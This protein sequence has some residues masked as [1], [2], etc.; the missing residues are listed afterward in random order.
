MLVSLK[1]IPF[2]P[3]KRNF[4]KPVRI[5]FQV[6]PSEGFSR[7]QAKRFLPQVKNYDMLLKNWIKLQSV[8]TLAKIE[9]QMPMINKNL[10]VKPVIKQ[11]EKII[12]N[13]P[14]ENKT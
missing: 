7:C 5:L 6:V 2:L 8:Q 4:A 14:M 1:E 12:E 11:F 9:T 10:F 3:E 13:P